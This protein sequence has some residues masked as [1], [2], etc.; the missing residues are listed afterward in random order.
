[1]AQKRPKTIWTYNG[2]IIETRNE[3]VLSMSILK[4]GPV[5]FRN[6]EELIDF[7]Q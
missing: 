4:I 3:S 7:L 2:W 1:M 6:T 5:I